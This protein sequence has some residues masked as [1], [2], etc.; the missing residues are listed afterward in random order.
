MFTRVQPG[1]AD[2]KKGAPATM[3]QHKPNT[4][5]AKTAPGKTE[6]AKPGTDHK[7]AIDKMNPEHLHNLVQSA[8]AGKFGPEAQRHAQQAMQ[9]APAQ[10]A[11]QEGAPGEQGGPDFAGMFGGG[12]AAPQGG[13]QEDEQPSAGSMFGGRC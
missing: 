6:P 9:S 4:P 1:T 11:P 10:G 7:A 13:P 8:H 12:G 2:G 5:P 3:P